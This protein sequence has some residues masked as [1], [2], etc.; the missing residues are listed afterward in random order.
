[1]KRRKS[2]LSHEELRN[3][4]VWK[5]L[6]M[7]MR[8]CIIELAPSCI[9]S[10]TPIFAGCSVFPRSR[11]NRIWNCVVIECRYNNDNYDNK[12]ECNEC[13][14]ITFAALLIDVSCDDREI[15]SR[16]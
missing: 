8:A 15:S 6:V 12:N 10:L 3:S 4:D 2:G 5:N 11:I 16:F 13:L 7:S 1:M 14:R 9:C